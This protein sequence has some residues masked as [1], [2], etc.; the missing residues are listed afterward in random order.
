MSR[1]RDRRE[2]RV[3]D[4]S[5]L[6]FGFST[7]GLTSS[8]IWASFAMLFLAALL[9]LLFIVFSQFCFC[10]QDMNSINS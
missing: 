9:V 1:S 10:K 5:W 7:A 3:R 4:T 6:C 8:V 2:D